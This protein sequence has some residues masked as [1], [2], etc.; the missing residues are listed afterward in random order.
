MSG[1]W[2]LLLTC[3][4][5]VALLWWLIR[6]IRG[7]PEA[8]SKVNLGKSFYTMGILALLIIAIIFVCVLFLRT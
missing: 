6:S 3:L 8:F 7:N 1:G 4:L 2:A 5:A